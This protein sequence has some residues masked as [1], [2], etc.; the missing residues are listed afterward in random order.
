MATIL[1][2]ILGSA[3]QF[4]AELDGAVAST[5]KA[6]GHFA[7]MGKAAGVAGAAITGGLVFGLVKSVEA[8][9]EAQ[10]ATARMNAAFVASHVSVKKFAG[11][12]EEA[13][14]KARKLG[15][16][17]EDVKGSLGSLI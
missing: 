12:I 8:A 17:N 10:Q 13:E 4:K 3:K 11:G 14:G 7:K 15:F 6:N 1:V 9:D 2:E 5:E 16:T